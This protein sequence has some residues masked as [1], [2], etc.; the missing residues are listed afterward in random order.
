[1]FS[2]FVSRPDQPL[3]YHLKFRVWYQPFDPAIH[4][5]V[6]RQTWGIASPVERARP[7][8]LAGQKQTEGR[9]RSEC[10]AMW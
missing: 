9:S 2:P 3:K 4:T 5:N 8:H 1:M 7:P 10:S 6:L